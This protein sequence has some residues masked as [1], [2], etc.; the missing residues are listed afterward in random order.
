MY[1]SSNESIGFYH[2]EDSKNRVMVVTLLIAA[3]KVH[4]PVSYSHNK[5]V[6]VLTGAKSSF[7]R[8]NGRCLGAITRYLDLPA[9]FRRFMK[10]NSAKYKLNVLFCLFLEYF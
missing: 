7:R 3:N 10:D 9:A 2:I 5:Q 1:L 8:T 6:I 4:S